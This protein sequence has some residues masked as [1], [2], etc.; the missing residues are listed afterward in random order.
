MIALQFIGMVVI[1]YLVGA[2][3]FGVIIGKMTRGIDVREYGSG[4]MGM[5]NVMRTVGAK[6]GLI[7]LIFD[8]F[9]GAGVVAL[10]WAVFYSANHDMVYWGQMAGGASAVIGHSWPIYIG[11]RGGKG[12]ATAAG[13]IL[14]LSWQVGLICLAVFLLMALAFRYI[15]LG[16]IIAAIALVVSMV[17]FFTCYSGPAAYMAFSLVVAPIVIFRHR[18]NIKRLLAGTESKIGQ[19]VK[20]K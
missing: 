14:V 15:S 11:F 17:V 5:T 3:P 6:A 12:I 13:A 8:V 20:V 10:A 4:S 16:S 19:K 9:K 1:G 7:V 2:I 18:G